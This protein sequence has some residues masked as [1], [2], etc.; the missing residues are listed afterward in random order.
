MILNIDSICFIMEKNPLKE[1]WHKARKRV[2]KITMQ[3][4]KTNKS[5]LNIFYT[6]G[7][8]NQKFDFLSLNYDAFWNVW[9]IDN[10]STCKKIGC[11]FLFGS[12]NWYPNFGNA[13]QQHLGRIALRYFTK[14]YIWCLSFMN[15]PFRKK[16]Y[17]IMKII[18][19]STYRHYHLWRSLPVRIF[20]LSSVRLSKFCGCCSWRTKDITNHKRFYHQFGQLPK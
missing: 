11:W 16:M 14:R 20:S 3:K 2:C 10:N 1:F 19:L 18:W 12:C 15:I 8:K 9:N 13:G 4:Y 5:S 17:L 6:K 7:Y